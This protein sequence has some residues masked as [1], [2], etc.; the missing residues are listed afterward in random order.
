[1]SEAFSVDV[2]LRQKRAS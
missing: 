1:M 2:T